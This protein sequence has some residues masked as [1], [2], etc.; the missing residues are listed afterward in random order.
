MAWNVR[1]TTCHAR[2][3]GVVEA[4]DEQTARLY[5]LSEFHIPADVDFEV[6]PR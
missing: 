5:A 6:S 3:L 2:W 4:P 1:I